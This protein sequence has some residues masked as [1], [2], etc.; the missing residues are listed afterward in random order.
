MSTTVDQFFLALK[1]AGIP[2]VPDDFSVVSEAQI[3]SRQAFEEIKTVVH[4][5]EQVTT[6]PSWQIGVTE[7]MP[8]I[9]QHRR[10]ESCFFSAWDFHIPPSE[11]PQI[12]EFN[13]NG[14][15]LFY[16]GLI[17]EQ[18]HL[19]FHADQAI[20]IE[21]P[22]S[23]VQL[24]EKILACIAQ[25]IHHFFKSQPQG[26]F[27]ILEHAE[28]LQHSKFKEELYLLQKLL[29]DQ[30][31]EAVI[32]APEETSYHNNQ[33]LWQ[34]KPVIFIINRTTDFLWETEN[35]SNIRTAYLAD[36]SCYIAPNPFTYGTRSY[37][38]LLEPLSLPDWDK[39]LGISSDEREIL[40]K[41]IPETHILREE[42]LELIAKRKE[43]FIF[44]PAQ[45]FA[46]QGLLNN[47]QV[48]RSRLRRLLKD[49]R[50]YVAQRKTPKSQLNDKNG[51]PMNLWVD[52][53]VWAYQ[54]EIL[55][56]SGRA[57]TRADGMDLSLPGGWVPTYVGQP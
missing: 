47:R 40:S 29:Q 1:K 34:G 15:G 28:V 55:A 17:N 54:G 4:V 35:F 10:S 49:N 38:G 30:G 11:K 16:A 32:G 37:K 48:G 20:G 41:H 39:K 23:F 26:I 24:K 14:S 44:K 19:A 50:G 21:S 5:F 52:L 22:L 8:E 9:T 56:L 36:Q 6:R 43:E 27:L 7:T 12:I 18:Y 33:L 3:I 13:D 2:S 53:R 42:N 46:A 57:S 51:K 31:Y 25:E 45:G